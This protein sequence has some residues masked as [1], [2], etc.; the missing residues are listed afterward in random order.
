MYFFFKKR[1]LEGQIPE[2]SQTLEAIK[3]L[4]E[5]SGETIETSFQLADAV[6]AKAKVDCNGKKIN[7]KNKFFIF[8][9]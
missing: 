6:Y 9:F 7:K 2:I 1:R 5:N 8:L 3:H 4:K